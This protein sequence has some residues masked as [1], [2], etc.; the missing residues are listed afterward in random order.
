MSYFTDNMYKCRDKKS[1]TNNIYYHPDMKHV[2]QI[3]NVTILME[4]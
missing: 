1:V 4:P 3:S 2:D